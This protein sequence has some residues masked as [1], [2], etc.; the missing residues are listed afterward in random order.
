[1]HELASSRYLQHIT[2][3]IWGGLETGF[4]CK[5]SLGSV[6]SPPRKIRPLGL[7][8]KIT[9]F[10]IQITSYKYCPVP[11][12]FARLCIQVVMDRS[13]H[14]RPSLI[15]KRRRDLLLLFVKHTVC[16][17]V[18]MVITHHPVFLSFLPVYLS[19]NFF[20]NDRKAL[21]KK[22]IQAMTTGSLIKL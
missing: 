18:V 8:L 13:S 21:I 16:Y 4:F 2:G 20:A 12:K 22:A 5:S 15:F 14:I 7:I 11:L 6:F 10:K 1:M 19:G 17:Q 9:C 3:Q